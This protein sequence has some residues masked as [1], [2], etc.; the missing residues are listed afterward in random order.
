[1]MPR[2]SFTKPAWSM[3]NGFARRRGRF[4]DVIHARRSS[5]P[6]SE[7]AGQNDQNGCFGQNGQNDP[8]GLVFYN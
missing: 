4:G 6:G 3:T 5:N 2:A 1:M 7:M 8:K